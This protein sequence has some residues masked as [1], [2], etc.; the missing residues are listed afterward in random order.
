MLGPAALQKQALTQATA[1]YQPQ[2][3]A[4]RA[5]Q[6]E[7]QRQ[8]AANLAG[9]QKLIE[10]VKAKA[11]SMGVPVQNAFQHGALADYGSSTLADAAR[12]SYADQGAAYANIGDAYEQAAANAGEGEYLNVVQDSNKIARDLLSEI[13]QVTGKIPGEAQSIYSDLVSAQD[14]YKTAQQ[15]QYEDQYDRQYRMAK[16]TVTQLNKGPWLYYVADTP[17]GPQIALAKG[18]N[19]KPISTT[20]MNDYEKARLAQSAATSNATASYRQQQLGLSQERLAQGQQRI[21][22]SRQKAA[23]AKADKAAKAQAARLKLPVSVVKQGQGLAARAF[24]GY[25]TL[26]DDDTPITQSQLI[27]LMKQYKVKSPAALYDKGGIV[28]HKQMTYQETL[29]ALLG[30]GYKLQPARDLLNRYWRR[31]AP[32]AKIVDGFILMPWET[33]GQ[34]RPLYQ[35]RVK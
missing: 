28:D 12:Q 32:G 20:G 34:G 21:D 4:L 2:L 16:D 25:Y 7:A 1:L 35:P 18:K 33:P 29:Q 30:L 13:A 3:D 10:V 8:A 27:Q 23:Q 22:I 19:G 26:P 14:K 24:K 5:D 17:Q 11:Q 31:N 15:K 9:I 6:R